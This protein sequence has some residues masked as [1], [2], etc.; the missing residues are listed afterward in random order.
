MARIALTRPRS[1]QDA[2]ARQPPRTARHKIDAQTQAIWLVIR[3]IYASPIDRNEDE[4][5]G[6]RREYLDLNADLCRRL[7]IWWGWM[8]FP[9]EV[10]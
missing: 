4:P 1:P 5:A 8:N 6:R 3:E 10:D 2:P 9:V 7:G